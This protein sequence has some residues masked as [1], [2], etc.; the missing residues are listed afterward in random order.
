[1]SMY[2]R[3]FLNYLNGICINLH[4][5]FILSNFASEFRE[6]P[7]LFVVERLFLS[8]NGALQ[9]FDRYWVKIIFINYF[10]DE[11]LR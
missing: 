4:K 3:I 1:M 5:S 6:Y 9:G 11:T 2:C 7:T 10:T 8:I